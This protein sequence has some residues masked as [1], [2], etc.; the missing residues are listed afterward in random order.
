MLRRNSTLKIVEGC[1]C[2]GIQVVLGIELG[3]VFG[4]L[5]VFRVGIGNRIAFG[6][7]RHEI[8]RLWLKKEEGDFIK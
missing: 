5:R 4:L 7:M 3:T 6:L 2:G 1:E 8:L